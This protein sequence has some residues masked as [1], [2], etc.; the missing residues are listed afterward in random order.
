MKD[1]I[2]KYCK[3]LRLSTTFADN[4]LSITRDTCQ[5]HLLKILRAELDYRSNK[6]K[7]LHLKQTTPDSIIA[8]NRLPTITFPFFIPPK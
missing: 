7:K 1:Q 3:E 5:E 6:R 4:E 2:Y 8:R